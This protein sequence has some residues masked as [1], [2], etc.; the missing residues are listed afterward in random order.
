VVELKDRDGNTE[1]Q[2]FARIREAFLDLLAVSGHARTELYSVPKIGSCELTE[3]ALVRHWAGQ[4]RV[5][6]G[7]ILVA[8][9]TAFAEAPERRNI[10]TSFR[11]VQPHIV[12]RIQSMANARVG[13]Q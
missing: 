11:Y 9:E 6:L 12:R 4:L 7:D 13:R 10:V 8:M 1:Q 5:D 2:R 3:E